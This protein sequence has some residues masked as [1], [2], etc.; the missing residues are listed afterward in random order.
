MRTK[1]NIFRSSLRVMF[2]CIYACSSYA[3]SFPNFCDTARLQPLPVL[4]ILAADWLRVGHVTRVLASGW[5]WAR[6][7]PLSAVT[8]PAPRSGAQS[9][10]DPARNR[11]TLT[12][13]VTVTRLP[14]I[15]RSFTIREKA[16]PYTF[17]LVE[18]ALTFTH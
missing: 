3:G 16:R 17:S 1:K 11:S 13:T 6:L 15:T 7:R 4:P 2:S 10:W 9:R 8:A 18:R 14:K 5:L 12:S